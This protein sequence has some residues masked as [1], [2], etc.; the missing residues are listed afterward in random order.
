M[1]GRF[2]IHV[3]GGEAER[4]FTFHY[5]LLCLLGAVSGSPSKG[6]GQKE[7]HHKVRYEHGKTKEPTLGR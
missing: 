6:I 1:I 7:I 3:K 5:C 2:Q 4:R